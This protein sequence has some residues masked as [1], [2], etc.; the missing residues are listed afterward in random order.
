M[1]GLMKDEW[2][3]KDKSKGAIDKRGENKEDF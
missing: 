1:R 2:R 3:E